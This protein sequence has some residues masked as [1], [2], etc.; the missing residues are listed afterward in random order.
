MTQEAGSGRRSRA[1][2]LLRYIAFPLDEPGPSAG[3]MLVCLQGGITLVPKEAELAVQLPSLGIQCRPPHV[4]IPFAITRPFQP[5]Y[6]QSTAS[7]PPFPPPPEKA[8]R[9]QPHCRCEVKHVARTGWEPR[10]NRTTHGFPHPV[11]IAKWGRPSGGKKALNPQHHKARAMFGG[12]QEINT[13]S[14]PLPPSPPS[15]T[16]RDHFIRP[17]LL[18]FVV[19]G[20]VQDTPWTFPS[21]LHHLCFDL[22]P[23]QRLETEVVHRPAFYSPLLK[24]RSLSCRLR[25]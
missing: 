6:R 20:F 23:L 21:P 10:N 25:R 11:T 19:C 16:H 7:D 15:L 12:T 9:E 18:C 3:V 4:P 24:L 5:R 13:F 2:L 17:L 8:E 14:F 22:D 1:T